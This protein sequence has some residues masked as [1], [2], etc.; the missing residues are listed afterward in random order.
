MN[1][2]SKSVTAPPIKILDDI[3]AVETAGI[4]GQLQRAI[5]D[6]AA[7]NSTAGGHAG[8]EVVEKVVAAS[9]VIP[10]QATER[11]IKPGIR[12]G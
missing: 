10:P 4:G 5:H 9:A 6:G 1:V 3:A 7:V 8:I 11:R 12:E 2:T